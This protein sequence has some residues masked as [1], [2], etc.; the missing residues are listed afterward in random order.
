MPNPKK[1]HTKWARDFRKAYEE[2]QARK[3]REYKAQKKFTFLKRKVPK[4]I[5]KE[6]E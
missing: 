2:E 5:R 4:D 3:L 6:I 1:D